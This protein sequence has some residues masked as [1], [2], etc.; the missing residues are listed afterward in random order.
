MKLNN[1]C[2]ICNKKININDNT[3]YKDKILYHLNCY[4]NK[5]K[6]LRKLTE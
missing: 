6:K 5:I 1:P 2:P 3:V 4:M